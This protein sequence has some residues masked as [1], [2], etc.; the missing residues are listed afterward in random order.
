MAGV[1]LGGLEARLGGALL[2]DERDALGGE[3][4]ADAIPAVQPAQEGPDGDAGGDLPVEH[5]LYGAVGRIG[6]TGNGNNVPFPS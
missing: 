5:R 1:D 2:D 3:P 4:R 6:Y